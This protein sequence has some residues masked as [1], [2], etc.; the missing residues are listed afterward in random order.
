MGNLETSFT[1]GEQNKKKKE[2]NS[3]KMKNTQNKV[4]RS[5]IIY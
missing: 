4:K 1:D 5:Q 3:E 2:F